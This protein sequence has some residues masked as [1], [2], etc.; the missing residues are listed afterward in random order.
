MGEPG[1]THDANDAK[2]DLIDIPYIRLRSFLETQIDYSASF[3]ELIAS[4]DEKLLTQDSYPVYDLHLHL[5]GTD[6]RVT[7]NGI[8]HTFSLPN[9]QFALLT[10]FI[11]IKINHG[12]HRPIAWRDVI[13]DA[14]LLEAYHIFYRTIKQGNFL[15]LE[16]DYRDINIIEFEKKDPWMNSS[17]WFKN[18]VLKKKSFSK[19]LSNLKKNLNEYLD[20][21]LPDINAEHF[22]KIEGR[23]KLLEK[24]IS[25]LIPLQNCRITGLHPKDAESLG[26][27]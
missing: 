22:I 3:D 19:E 8:Q 21:R 18:G 15:D 16:D 7:L 6:S 27:G 12:S 1:S 24:T 26:L 5:N 14:D 13:H 23:S 11:W 25:T 10:F 17:Y 9:R 4:A 20:A 2:I